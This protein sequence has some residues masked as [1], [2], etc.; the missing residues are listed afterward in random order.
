MRRLFWK[1]FTVVW[2]AM[3]GSIAFL[4]TIS[5]LFQSPFQEELSHR[6]QA[7]AM[8]TTSQLLQSSGPDAAMALIAAMKKADQDIT[9]SINAVGPATDCTTTQGSEF[10]T[11]LV[12]D[13]SCYRIE[14]AGP[15]QGVISKTWPRTVPWLAALLAAAAAAYWLARYF[16]SPVEQ[17][18]Y[19]LR[20]LANGQLDVR[21]AHTIGSKR[22]EITSL[23]HDLDITATRL[24]ELQKTQQQLFHD[25]SHE[26]RSPLSRLQAAIGVLQQNPA[27]LTAMIERMGR[28]VERLDQLVGEILTLA[29]LSE[30]GTPRFERQTLDVIDLVREIVEDASFE[31]QS[32]EVKVIYQGVETFVASVNGELIYR[33][34]ENVIRNAIAY[35]ETGT[36]V[37]V[38]SQV[39]GT[40]LSL[41]IQDEGLGVPESQLETIFQ[42]FS[43][44][45]TVT[46]RSGFGL[47]LAI[48]RRAA[49]WHG[50]GAT[51][52]NTPSGG[53]L[54]EITI[55]AN[56][57]LR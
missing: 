45:S 16:I 55:S 15:D 54:V 1:F 41:S 38:T 7:F 5:A 13:G 2:L 49:E 20:A 35:T 9:V 44:S 29:R 19:G 22:D 12:S 53:L 50:G 32:R 24:Q 46:T 14:I 21:I 39:R 26:L 6:K 31:G 36:S 11:N 51:A 40:N 57:D 18:R 8:E 52:S 30:R 33:A 28:E 37:L 48:T 47:G 42:P 10:A 34:L 17:L 3:A 25:V 43:Q 56:S 4:F 27:R 23:A